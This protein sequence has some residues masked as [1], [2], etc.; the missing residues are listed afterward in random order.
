MQLLSLQIHTNLNNTVLREVYNNDVKLF[1]I[2]MGTAV[3]R[4]ADLST[5]EYLVRFVS[6]E[7]ISPNDRSSK[8]EGFQ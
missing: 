1:Q 3:S 2:K 8:V 4:N 5:N 7:H 6:K